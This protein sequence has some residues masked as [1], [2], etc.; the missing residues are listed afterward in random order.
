MVRARKNKI[1]SSSQKKIAKGKKV[2]KAAETPVVKSGGNVEVGAG[3]GEGIPGFIFMCNRRT[4]PEC[5]WNRVFGLPA[6]R[7]EDVKKIQKKAKLFLF[8]VDLKLLYGIYEATSQGGMSLRPEA[9]GGSYPA[10]VEFKIVKDCLPLPQIAFKHAIKDNYNKSKFSQELN[11]CQV[12]NL[13]SL[14]RPINVPQSMPPP[15]LPEDHR[16]PPPCIPPTKED[17]YKVP[18]YM[19]QTSAP[20]ILEDH[21]ASLARLQPPEDPYRVASHVSRAPL[22]HD[23]QYIPPMALPPNGDSYVAPTQEAVISLGVD[24]RRTQPVES[25]PTSDSYYHPGTIPPYMPKNPMPQESYRPAAP[26]MIPRDQVP[27]PGLYHTY[28][29]GQGNPYY[30]QHAN[31]TTS[32]ELPQHGYYNPPAGYNYPYIPQYLAPGHPPAALPPSHGYSMPPP[33]GSEDPNRRYAYNFQVPAPGQPNLPANIP[34]SSLY[35]FA[36]AAP[37]YR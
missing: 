21:R 5:Y 22:V 33:P 6:S 30:T 31:H 18:P 25:L 20:Y 35:A 23:A 2:M 15:H 8:D 17:P 9:F 27:A 12:G 34:V 36:G 37:A 16:V 19:A 7:A 11:S 1:E 29:G 32:V 13:L 24:P 4:K 14:F 3:Q 28:Y 26:E 10:Q